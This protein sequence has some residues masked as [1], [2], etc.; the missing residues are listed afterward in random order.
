MINFPVS[1]P[2]RAA[3][4]SWTRRLATGA[5][6]IVLAAALASCRS[7]DDVTGSI[8]GA[9]NTTPARMAALAA[10]YDR[11][12]ENKAA[13]MNYARAL[14]AAGRTNEVVAVLQRLGARYPNDREILSAYGKALAEA[15]RLKEAASVLQ[16]AHTPERPDWSVLFA[17]GSVADQMG[18]HKVAQGFY[19][20][21]LRISAAWIVK[22]RIARHVASRRSA[23]ATPTSSRRRT[24]RRCR[25]ATH[26]SAAARVRPAAPVS[27]S[28]SV[29]PLSRTGAWPGRPRGA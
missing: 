2:R 21:A 27:K 1:G 4:L 7:S 11:A 9:V 13:A 14:R 3:C 15:G 28:G 10:Q 16:G 23:S 5:G 29:S 19:A 24:Q 25:R 17:Q 26:R 18:D 20:S 8:G 12:P 6:V 22:R